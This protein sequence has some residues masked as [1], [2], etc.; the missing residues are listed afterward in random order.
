MALRKFPIPT[1][2]R[3]LG[4]VRVEKL[5]IPQ[6]IEFDYDGVPLS[7]P[8]QQSVYNSDGN[9]N[10]NFVQNWWDTC[11]HVTVTREEADAAG[12]KGLPLAYF[13]KNR[14][15]EV[16]PR[17]EERSKSV[18]N[19]SGIGPQVARMYGARPVTDFGILPY[20]EY[21]GCFAQDLTEF[22]NGHFCNETHA[23]RV[24]HDE[25]E[26]NI[27]PVGDSIRARNW[28]KS[29]LEDAKV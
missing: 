11:T 15:G 23:A 18:R 5:V 25:R 2:A 3:S 1:R 22:R 24:W 9:P 8:C 27:T 26:P 21:Y 10:P 4:S 6:C 20:C 13:E 19:S 28:V 14:G 17:I 7:G 12:Y 29:W 16:R